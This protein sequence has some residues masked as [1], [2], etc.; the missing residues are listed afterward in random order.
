[1]LKPGKH[2]IVIR[3]DNAKQYDISHRDMAHAYTEGTQI[4]WNGIIGKME[5]IA[6]SKVHIANLQVYPNLKEQSAAIDLEIQNDRQLP[7]KANLQIRILDREKKLVVQK[8]VTVHIPTGKTSRKETLLFAHILPWD[9]FHPNVYTTE[10]VLTGTNSKMKDVAVTSFGVRQMTTDNSLLQVNGRRVFL[11]GTLECNIFPLTGHPPMEKAGWLKE[12][13]TAKAYGLNHIRF[14][15]WCPPQAAFEVADSMGFYLQVELPFWSEKLNGDTLDAGTKHFIEKEAIRISEEYGN[16]PS[17]C[18][19]SM[20]NEIRG[21][22]NWLS[23]MVRTLKQKDPRH[24][25]TS[26][27]FTFQKDHGKWPEPGDDFFVTQYTRKRWVRGQGIFNSFAPN[28]STDYSAAIDSLPV[29]IISHEIGQYSIYPNLDE[30]KKY[31]GVLEPTNFK[32]IGND[33]RKKDLLHLDS[34]FAMASGKFSASLYKEEIE[35]ALKTKGMSGFQLLDLHDFPGQGTALVGILDAFWDSK[36]LV[37]PEEHR[38]YCSPVVPLLR[39]AKAV[40]TNTE[41]FDATAEIANFSK[42]TLQKVV[43]RWTVTDQEGKLVFTGVLNTQTIALG[44][45]MELGKISFDLK[46]FKEA[47]QLTIALELKG[48]PYKNKWNIWVYPEQTTVGRSDVIFTT[49]LKEALH[50]LNE[51]KKVLLNPDTVF[52]NGVEGRFAPVFWSPVHFPNQPGTMGLLCHPNHEALKYFPTEFYSGWQWW[53]LITSSKTMCIDSLPD[54]QPVVRIIDNFYK[55]R[56]LATII[57]AK[58]GKGKLVLTSLDLSHRLNERPA[59]KQ[60]RYSL[61]NYMMSASFSPAVELNREQLS[62]LLKEN[63]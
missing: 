7:Q 37:S 39:F 12:F 32:A 20:G 49:S 34:A 30:I 40:Y 36:G 15:S 38:M 46:E 62:F 24:L 9:E 47:V 3:I 42:G 33:L 16:H 28:F 29:P 23:G 4:I 57:E 48:T 11:R 61:E 54:M 27:T 19:W 50:F 45:G 52:I 58:V 17:F 60:L 44:N 55:N 14:H 2:L 43:P 59:A 1:L 6:R 8:N 22:F 51:G 18:L 41:A 31:T 25:Y 53:D 10:V 21:D 13:T 63:L 56:K 26:T 35:R 5:L